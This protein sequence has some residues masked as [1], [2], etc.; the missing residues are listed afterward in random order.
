MIIAINN[1]FTFWSNSLFLLAKNTADKDKS[2]IS[3]ANISQIYILSLLL[4]DIL[5][6]KHHTP[7]G[8]AQTHPKYIQRMHTE[9]QNT[10]SKNTDDLQAVLTMSDT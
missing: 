9:T 4:E 1:T 3:M 7:K 2:S 6:K 10:L 8:I 5:E